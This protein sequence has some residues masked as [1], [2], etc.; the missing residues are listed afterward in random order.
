MVAEKHFGGR[1]GPVWSAVEK[2]WHDVGVGS[3]SICN[4]YFRPK[5]NEVV[6]QDRL[7]DIEIKVDPILPYNQGD[8]FDVI[9][10]DWILPPHWDV[11]YNGDLSGFTLDDVAADFSSQMITAIV[12]YYKTGFGMTVFYDTLTFPLH[13]SNECSSS[14]KPGRQNTYTKHLTKELSDVK[15]YP[16]PTTTELFIEGLAPGT[17]LEIYTLVGQKIYEYTSYNIFERI[18]TGNFINGTYLLTLTDSQG[19]KEVRRIVKS[20]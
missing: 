4:Q 15:V 20:N 19:I 13:F 11:T 1:C 2:A 17:K 12:S 3:P 18:N 7:G 9:D 6:R 10:Y 8:D 16:N 14:A 5:Y